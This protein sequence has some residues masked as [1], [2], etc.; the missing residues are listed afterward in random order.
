MFGLILVTEIHLA[1]V[2]LALAIGLVLIVWRPHL[3]RLPI[4]IGVL[5]GTVALGAYWLARG[6]SA[7]GSSEER[8]GI[9]HVWR[10][11]PAAAMSVSGIFWSLEFKEGYPLFAHSLGRWR[12]PLE[13][14][15]L[16]PVALLA[17]GLATA[18]P[19]GVR[20]GS[21][22]KT[23]TGLIVLL[24]LAIPLAFVLALIRTSP[25]YFPLWY[26]LPFVLI[27][28]AA[29]RL[30]ARAKV[31]AAIL[32]LVVLGLQL[33]FFTRQLMYIDRHGG[34]P[35]S[36]LGLSYAGLLED[37]AFAAAKVEA[38][39]VWVEYA[40][41]TP[42]MRE[43]VPYVFRRGSWRPGAGRVALI[44]YRPPWEGG[45]EVWHMAS[46]EDVPPGAFQVH[47]WSGPRQQHARIT[48]TPASP[49]SHDTIGR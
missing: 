44:V 35:K 5:T 6:S 9:L 4:A 27:G 15:M 2:V 26:P 28:L 38:D 49:A 17:I 23:G 46:R 12:W 21:F 8:T 37:R 47:P 34:V 48:E 19:R 30:T 29:Q 43:A 22:T 39:E 1:G 31:P 7:D 13:L 24:V 33:Y 10:T 18:W 3:P 36:V 20:F 25:T 45:S 32:L 41:E 40:G 11:I 16:V 42:I 14:V